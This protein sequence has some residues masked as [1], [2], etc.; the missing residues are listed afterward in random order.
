MAIR[1]LDTNIV[2]YLFKGHSLAARYLSHLQ[3]HIP[4]VSFMT[5]AELYEWAFH[6]GWGPRRIARLEML[7]HGYFV[8]PSSPDLCRRWAEVRFQR[9]SQPIGVADAWIAATAML[10]GIDLITHNPRDFAGLA[11]LTVITEAGP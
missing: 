8:I 4:A 3:G 1:L 11:G 2:S 10:N 5:V 7:L 9:R 6:A